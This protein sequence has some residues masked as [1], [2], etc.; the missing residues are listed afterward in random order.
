MDFDKLATL[1][2]ADVLHVQL[3][4]QMLPG[5]SLQ[6]PNVGAYLVN[7]LQQRVAALEQESS[8]GS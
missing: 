5:S 4:S 3:V 7:V 6:V 1:P 2:P 8:G